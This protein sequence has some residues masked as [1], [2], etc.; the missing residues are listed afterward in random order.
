MLASNFGPG[1]NHRFS[2]PN[3]F[4]KWTRNVVS[5]IAII[6]LFVLSTM[7]RTH[8]SAWL[9]SVTYVVTATLASS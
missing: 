7:E 4:L 1:S 6:V 2:P 3:G 9:I 8:R 5:T